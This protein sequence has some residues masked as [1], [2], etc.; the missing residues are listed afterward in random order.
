MLSGQ[1]GKRFKTF[2][3]FLM[4]FFLNYVVVISNVCYASG[5][6]IVIIVIVNFI[7]DVVCC[8]WEVCVSSMINGT[9]CPLYNP[10]LYLIVKF[11]KPCNSRLQFSVNGQFTLP[12]KRV[13]LIINLKVSC[14]SKNETTQPGLEP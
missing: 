10:I 1:A 6:V 5:V 11:Q 2:C 14:L 12:P 4:L 8:Y 3:H 13:R 9:K 7:D